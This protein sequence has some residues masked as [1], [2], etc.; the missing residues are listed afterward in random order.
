MKNAILFMVVISLS[1]GMM[2]D[3]FDAWNEKYDGVVKDHVKQSVVKGIQGSYVD[4][5]ALRG[6]RRVDELRRALASL[7]SLS[8][9]SRNKRLAC[10]MNYYNFLTLYIVAKNPGLKG[11][12][13]LNKPGKNIWNQDAG[14]VSGK[15]YT[16]DHIEHKI[17][18]SY[19]EPRIHFALVCAAVSCPNLLNEAYTADKLEKQLAKQLRVFALNKKKGI[20]LDK[21]NKTLKLSS[22]FDWFKSDFSNDSKKWLYNN[23]II[24]R[25]AL[26]YKV[27]YLNYD[28]DLNALPG[29]N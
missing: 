27:S 5:K 8:S 20:H 28:W 18:R 15:S 29:K 12:Q 1:V 21:Y 23:K 26:S 25:Y 11:L 17:I 3:V 24:P 14:K 2:A 13:D 4:Y 22:L 10:W 16:L 9:Q 7:P 6:D 19:G